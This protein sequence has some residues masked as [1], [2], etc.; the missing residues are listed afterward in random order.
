MGIKIN[1]GTAIIIVILLFF[2]T[3]ALRIYISY[4][5]EIS[6]VD[7][8]YYV[9]ELNYQQHIEKER[10]TSSLKEKPQIELSQKTLSIHFPIYFNFQKIEGSIF[11]YRPSDPARDRHFTISLDSNLA[12]LVHIDNL[13]KGVYEVKIDWIADGI[14]YYFKQDIFAR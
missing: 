7:E 9:R 4:Q 12:Q 11:L 5:N 6:L 8:D 3:I 10:N 13:I 1:W 14:P 2:G